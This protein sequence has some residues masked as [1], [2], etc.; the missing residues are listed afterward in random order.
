MNSLAAVVAITLSFS[1][2]TWR[3]I[4]F[5]LVI[6]TA[7]ILVGLLIWGLLAA[8]G[9]MND[10]WDLEDDSDQNPDHEEY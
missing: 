4:T 10:L 9:D 8:T 7:I 6:V 1:V 3:W 2:S 5:P